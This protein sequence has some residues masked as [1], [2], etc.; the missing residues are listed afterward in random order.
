M[1]S[2]STAAGIGARDAL[3]SVDKILEELD[4]LA[5]VE[6]TDGD[7]YSAVMGRLRLLGCSAAA[8]W[9]VPPGGEPNVAWQS[10]EGQSDKQS[11]HTHQSIVAAAIQSGQPKLIEKSADGNGSHTVGVRSVIAPWSPANLVHGAVQVWFADDANSPAAG[12]LPVLAAVGELVA[13]FFARQEQRRLRQRVDRQ[14]QVDA[15]TRGLHESLDTQEIAYRIANDGRAIVGCDRLAVAIRRGSGYKIVAVSGADQIHA[16]AESMEQLERLCRAVVLSGE[17]LWHTATADLDAL[18]MAP[19][20]SQPLA[21][22]LDVSAAAGLA[23]VPLM[24]AQ[25]S[26]KQGSPLAVLVLEQ[27]DGPLS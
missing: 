26:P 9:L 20:L 18:E 27:F 2:A 16:R 15:F 10:A 5:A 8:F 23:V 7:F 13:M 19:Q 1:A 4:R 17:P 22:Y 24:G 6:L 12:Y 25:G 21:G 3:Q 14:A 11:P